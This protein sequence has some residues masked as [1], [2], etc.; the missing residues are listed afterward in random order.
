MVDLGFAKIVVDKTYTLCGTPEY[1]AP[2]IIMSKGHDKAVDYWY[3]V[4]FWQM[5]RNLE[6]FLFP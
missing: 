2:E 5:R 1:L 6:H 4:T 3:V